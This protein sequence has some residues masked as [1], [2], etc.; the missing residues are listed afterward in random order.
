MNIGERIKSRRK[1][2]GLSVDYI[3]ENLD[4]NRATIY[5][6][7][8]RDIE[9]LPVTILEPLAKLL[10]T[11]P[12]Y[13]MGWEESVTESNNSSN[14]FSSE[15]LNLIDDFRKLN[16]VGRKKVSAYTNDLID[17]GKYG[18]SEPIPINKQKEIWEEEGKEHLM[19]IACHDDNL[20]EE[21]KNIMNKLIEE[22]LKNNN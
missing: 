14:L 21:E 12:E 13:L 3:A 15:E 16:I 8:S 6:Y 20:T 11:T 7:E 1:E 18:K 22:D 10:Q 2:L 9:N 17:S 5:R 4:K 19:P